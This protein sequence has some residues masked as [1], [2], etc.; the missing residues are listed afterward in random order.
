MRVSGPMHHLFSMALR[1]AAVAV[2][3]PVV[4]V[5]VIDTQAPLGHIAT[6]LAAVISL[7]QRSSVI[8]LRWAERFQ[9]QAW[10][11]QRERN[12]IVTLPSR[13]EAPHRNTEVS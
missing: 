6:S 3:I 4:L 13:I 12:R 7:W 1:A 9:Y 5:L 2:L 8:T 11:Q 10:V